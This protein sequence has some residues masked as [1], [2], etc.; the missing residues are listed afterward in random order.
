MKIDTNS[1]V[2]EICLF[3]GLY[4][5]GWI[6][7]PQIKYKCYFRRITWYGNRKVYIN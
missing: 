5:S 4:R 3:L 2:N 6:V 1:L 7:S